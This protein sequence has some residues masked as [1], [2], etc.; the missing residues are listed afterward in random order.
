MFPFLS[1]PLT[2]CS[3]IFCVD[4]RQFLQWKVKRFHANLARCDCVRLLTARIVTL[5]LH[6]ETARV[7]CVYRCRVCLCHQQLTF[8]RETQV[9]LCLPRVNLTQKGAI[10][11]TSD[12]L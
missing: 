2:Q 10:L 1:F 12:S 6:A 4:H 7:C 5:T 3:L 11:N 9:A 8:D